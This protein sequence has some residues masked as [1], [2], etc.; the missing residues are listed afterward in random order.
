MNRPPCVLCGVKGIRQPVIKSR[1]STAYFVPMDKGG[2]KVARNMFT[3]CQYHKK[4]YTTWATDDEREI[5]EKTI[6]EHMKRV[7]PEWNMRQC[8][9]EEER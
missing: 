7:Y 1:I 4:L 3:A 2:K 6:K 5:A 8:F 9:Q